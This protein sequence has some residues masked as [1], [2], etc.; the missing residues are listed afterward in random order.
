MPQIILYRKSKL[1]TFCRTQVNPKPNMAEI[2]EFCAVYSSLS[3]TRNISAKLP[4]LRNCWITLKVERDRRTAQLLYRI[5]GHRLGIRFRS[6]VQPNVRA[7]AKE[8]SCCKEGQVLLG[9]APSDIDGAGRI[10]GLRETSPGVSDI[11]K[12]FGR[13]LE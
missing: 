10:A 13:R 12:A 9:A 4:L 8:I 6:I 5:S 1:A 7:L 2:P 3:K 11:L